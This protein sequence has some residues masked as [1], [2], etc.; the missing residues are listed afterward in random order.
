MCWDEENRLSAIHDRGEMSNLSVY[1]YN[2]TG[3]RVW[4]L[5]G[6]EMQVQVNGV[7]SYSN[8][9]FD[10]T[11]YASPYLVMDEHEYTKHYYIE[12]ERIC[13]KLGGGFGPAPV[14]PTSTPLNFIEGDENQVA[15][16][17]LHLVHNHIYCTGYSGNWEISHTLQPAYNTEHDFEDK[18]YF[19]H[20]DHLGSSSFITN[21]LGRAEQHLQYLPFGELWI[22]QRTSSFDSPYKFSAKELDS[23]SG[24]NYFGARYY[25]SE[26]SIWLSVDPMAHEREWLSPYNYC[27]LNPINRVD[28]TGAL[29]DNYSVDDDG[30]VKKEEDTDDD[31]DMLY[32]KSDWDA[33]NT[34]N[35]LKVNDRSILPDLETKRTNVDGNYA[36][37]TNR[38]EAFNVFYFM[39]NNTNVEWGIDGYRTSGDNEYILKTSHSGGIPAHVFNSTGIDGYDEFNMIFDMHSHTGTATEPGTKGASGFG[40]YYS[41]DMSYITNRYRRFQ[42]AGM[43]NTS[44]WFKKD[45]Q[46]TVFPKHYVYHKQSKV[47]YHYTPWKNNVFIRNTSK[48]SDLYRNLGF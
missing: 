48:A 2:D 12:G 47:L 25:D 27:S 23:E 33:G 7:T 1:L 35:G 32:T 9:N 38:N 34:D 21:A 22:N 42:G 43:K 46:W 4:K 13:S 20:P 3:E 39:A 15:E 6:D 16:T 14:Q 17:L 18:Q 40:D 8:V 36:I 29:D 26:A 5:T 24:Y 41:G 30:N 19:Y 37:T 11:L 10:K 31:F 45:D 44:T 28:P